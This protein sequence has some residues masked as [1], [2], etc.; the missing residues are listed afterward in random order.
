[1]SVSESRLVTPAPRPLEKA[2]MP[3]VSPLR[4]PWPRRGGIMNGGDLF[5]FQDREGD[6]QAVGREFLLLS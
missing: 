5:V 4:W 3:A 1:M 6:D 2:Q